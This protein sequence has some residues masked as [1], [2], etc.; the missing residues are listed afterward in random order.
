MRIEALVDLGGE[1][2]SHPSVKSSSFLKH[3]YVTIC[4]IIGWRSN[5]WGCRPP[6]LP[7]V[8]SWIRHCRSISFVHILSSSQRY[9]PN[10]ITVRVSLIIPTQLNK[11]P[12]KAAAG[13]GV[14]GTL[15]GM[16]V[17]KAISWNWVNAWCL[18]ADLPHS[19]CHMVKGSSPAQV[20]L[21][22]LFHYCGNVSVSREMSLR[23]PIYGSVTLHGT[24]NWVWSGSG[25]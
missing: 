21:S 14:L 17:T 5:L 10:L 9:K 23:H 2:N 7:F 13:I 4:Q 8:K 18:L 19:K 24:W 25:K 16:S 6:P 12:Y 20:A 15:M 3:F 22:Q 1:G 11:N